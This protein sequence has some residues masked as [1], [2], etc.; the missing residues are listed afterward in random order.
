MSYVPRRRDFGSFTASQVSPK[1]EAG[2]KTSGFLGRIMAA[3]FATRQRDVDRQ[4]A[5]F[6]GARAS[7][8]LTD[9]LEREISQRLLTSDWRPN[10]Q[11][12][13]GSRFS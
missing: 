6:L 10:T 3:L 4:I 7:G 2:A 9:G 1:L 13:R 12:C 5:R 8:T 11:P